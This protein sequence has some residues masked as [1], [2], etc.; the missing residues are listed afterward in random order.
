MLCFYRT[1][2]LAL[3]VSGVSGATNRSARAPRVRT[4]PRALNALANKINID[5]D[6]HRV[7]GHRLL[8]VGV[9]KTL[10][11]KTEGQISSALQL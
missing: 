8:I 7:S 3:L 9:L 4:G 1:V 2:L 5:L 10:D 6:H 11:S